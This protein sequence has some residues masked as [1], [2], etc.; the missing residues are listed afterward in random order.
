M[1]E[2]LRIDRVRID[3]G[4]QSVELTWATAQE[5]Q[6]RMFRFERTAAIIDRFHRVGTSRPVSLNP[7]DVGPMLVVVA[8]WTKE[9]GADRLPPSIGELFAAL[10]IANNSH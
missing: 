4:N 2:R 9:I 8:Q 3:T 6:A 5:L 7:E 1:A 10:Q